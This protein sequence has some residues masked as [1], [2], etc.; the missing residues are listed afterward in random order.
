MAKIIQ[1]HSHLNTIMQHMVIN[2]P[3]QKIFFTDLHKYGNLCGFNLVNAHYKED[4]KQ[5]PQKKKKNELESEFGM[6]RKH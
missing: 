2:I 1:V 4:P 3:D 5:L 6:P